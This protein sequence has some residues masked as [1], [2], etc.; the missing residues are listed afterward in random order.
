[1]N[2]SFHDPILSILIILANSF[3]SAEKVLA[4]FDSGSVNLKC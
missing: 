4:V 1:M 3:S 2:P